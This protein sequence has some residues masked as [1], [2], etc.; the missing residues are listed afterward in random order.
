MV[1][2]PRKLPLAKNFGVRGWLWVRAPRNPDILFD[3]EG[4]LEPL[5]PLIG[6]RLSAFSLKTEDKR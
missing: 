5:W 6:I 3:L 2:Q 4:P 1:E